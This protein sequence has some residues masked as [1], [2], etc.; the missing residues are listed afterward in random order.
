MRLTQ[1]AFSFLPDLT[2]AQISSQIEY[3]LKNG[4]AV[5]IEYTDDP[6]PRNTYWEMFGQPMF[7]IRD[8]AGIMSE[9]QSCR[10]TFPQ[11]YIK[12]NAFDSSLGRE[13]LRLSFNVGRPD[14]EPGF[15]LERREMG[16]RNV[17]Y[18]TRSYAVE[19]PEGERY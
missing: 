10:Q 1:G 15:A 11:H 13:S 16:G 8:A 14:K 19:R 6:H 12:V 18:T 7:D 2:D 17:Q 5:S 9:L 4:W 3:C